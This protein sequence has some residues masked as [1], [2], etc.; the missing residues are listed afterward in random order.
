M[1]AWGKTERGFVIGTFRDRYEVLS[2]IQESSLAWG[3]GGEMSDHCIWLGCETIGKSRLHLSREMAGTIAKALQ[4]FH[5][6]GD[7]GP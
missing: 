5:D 7:I 6:T 1:I 2:S 4:R 3:K